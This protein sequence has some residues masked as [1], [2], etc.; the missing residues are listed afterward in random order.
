MTWHLKNSKFKCPDC[1]KFCKEKDGVYERYLRTLF[2]MC[3]KCAYIQLQK[4]VKR[5]NK[6][7]TKLRNNEKHF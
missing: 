7:L 1:N 2:M 4:K 3:Y 6:E 5:M